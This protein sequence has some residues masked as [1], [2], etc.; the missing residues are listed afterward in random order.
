MLLKESCF[1]L[2]R[3]YERKLLILIWNKVMNAIMCEWLKNRYCVNGKVNG[4]E[5]FSYISVN[6]PMCVNVH[7]ASV[8]MSNFFIGLRHH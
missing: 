8:K 3:V 4:I 6:V 5:S 2:L 7:R 1:P